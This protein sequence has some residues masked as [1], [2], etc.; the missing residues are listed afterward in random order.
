MILYVFIGIFFPVV[1][2]VKS[3]GT[4]RADSMTERGVC[5]AAD[6]GFNLVPVAL[7]IPDFLARSANRKH[8][9]QGSDFRECIL[10]PVLFRPQFIL[11][12]F[13]LP[14]FGNKLPPP[15]PREDGKGKGHYPDNNDYFLK[16][17]RFG[18]FYIPEYKPVEQ[19]EKY[20]DCQNNHGNDGDPDK[21]PVGGCAQFQFLFE[22]ENN[23]LPKY[24]YIFE[25]FDMFPV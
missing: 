9:A 6:I 1:F 19:V 16:F 24:P 10:K 12:L 8:T 3:F 22:S 14:D 17:R 4:F 20:G 18:L 25:I 23:D 11:D 13:P 21:V 15:A 2:G 5:I 7:V